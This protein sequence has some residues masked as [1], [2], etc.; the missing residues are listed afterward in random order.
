MKKGHPP[1]MPGSSRRPGGLRK[2]STSWPRANCGSRVSSFVDTTTVR[3]RCGSTYTTHALIKEPAA[4]AD[5]LRMLYHPCLY[6]A[7]Q[8]TW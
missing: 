6:E 5:C 8:L 1:S 2:S 4:P 3:D 7:L